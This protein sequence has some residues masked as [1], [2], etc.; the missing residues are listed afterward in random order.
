MIDAGNY[1]GA[2]EEAAPLLREAIS[3]EDW[4]RTMLNFR[5]PLGAVLSRT[6]KSAE[7]KT[8]LPGVPDGEYILIQYDTS[9]AMKKSSVET[10]TPMRD[11][12]GKW[13]V[14]GYFIN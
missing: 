4:R 2:W 8:Q 1:G 5:R 9:F 7:Y 13:R 3:K 14:S 12:D 10:V 11:K 6:L